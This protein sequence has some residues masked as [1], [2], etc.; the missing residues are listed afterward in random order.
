MTGLQHFKAR[1]L[2]A[3]LFPESF[4][5]E[6]FEALDKIS[7]IYPMGDDLVSSHN[8]LN[9]A[10]VLFDGEKVFIID[11]E[12]AFLNDRY[13]DLAILALYFAANDAHIQTLLTAYFGAAP[14]AYQ[15]ARFYLMRQVVFL[16]YATIFLR[17]AADAKPADFVHDQHMVTP[18][19][20]EVKRM[21]GSGE[22]QLGTYEGKLLYGKM[23]LQEALQ[24]I[25]AP[26]FAAALERISQPQATTV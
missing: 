14:T 5:S 11:W 6:H 21:L 24:G 25:K 7:A 1:F 22:V 23:L 16:Y 17:L 12:A 15:Q 9:P 20:L 3:K 8:D 2:E 19:L 13:V 4:T 10:N 18:G 26:A